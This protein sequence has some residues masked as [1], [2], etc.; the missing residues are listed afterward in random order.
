MSLLQLNVKVQFNGKSAEQKVQKAN[1]R[2]LGH[3][4]GAIRKTAARS[5]RR[6]KKRSKPDEPPHTPSGQLKRVIQ[7]EV[8]ERQS[9]VVIGPIVFAKIGIKSFSTRRTKYHVACQSKQ[10]DSSLSRFSSV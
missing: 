10:R 6:G 9:E 7:Y 8:D 2:S 4:G 3:A 5:I 1:F